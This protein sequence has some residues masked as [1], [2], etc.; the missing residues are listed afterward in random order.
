MLDWL[1]SQPVY[2]IKIAGHVA[3]L[4][5]P[6]DRRATRVGAFEVC[7]P[8]HAALP[9]RTFIMQVLAQ[10]R[11]QNFQRGGGSPADTNNYDNLTR[12]SR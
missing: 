3:L 4:S 8:A 11:S 9:I 6:T 10:G 2:R 7:N 1:L 12:L 5:G